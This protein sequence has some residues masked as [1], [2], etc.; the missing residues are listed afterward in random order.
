MALPARGDLN[1]DQGL[2]EK[3]TL[4]RHDEQIVLSA[5]DMISAANTDLG[6]RVGGSR[7]DTGQRVEPPPVRRVRVGASQI[8]SQ[9]KV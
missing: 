1:V 5:W 4:D 3:D 8:K 9:R 6:T 7:E 2:S